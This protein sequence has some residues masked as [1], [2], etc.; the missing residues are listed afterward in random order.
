[1]QPQTP[2]P[3][4]L[5]EILR[6][7]SHLLRG[8]SMAGLAEYPAAALGPHRSA[9][10]ADAPALESSPGSR[11]EQLDA[12]EQELADCTRCR[13]HQG[14][15]HL[16]FGEGA[17]HPPVVFVGEGPGF[18]EDRQGR[19]FVGRAGRL[20]DKMIR[21]MGMEREDVYI[22]N[23][24]KC[25]PPRNR[26]PQADEIETCF[27]F[28]VRQLLS[29]SPRVIVALGGCAAQTLLGTGNAISRL[30]G[31]VYAWRGIP[32]ICT[33]HPA[34]LLRNPGQKHAAW[35]DLLQTRELLQKSPAEN[36]R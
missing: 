12:I 17:A 11:P 20:L 16:V 13:L 3:E 10:F 7:L 5:S 30:R 33:F 8:Y 31:K 23:V 34:Y 29:L 6:A 14:R 19:P 1:M 4:A 15:T 26:T 9:G 24:V 25:R 32:L 21:S 36:S 27:P 35:Q 22:C 18:E 28:L 2:A